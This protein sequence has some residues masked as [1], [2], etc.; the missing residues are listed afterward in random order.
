MSITASKLVGERITLD[1]WYTDEM[2]PGEQITS[3]EIQVQV[4]YGLDPDPLHIVYGA[5]EFEEEDYQKVTHQFH[6]GIPGCIYQ[7]ASVADTSAGRRLSRQR[8]LAILPSPSLVPPFTGTLY[9]THLYPLETREDLEHFVELTGRL[10][11]MP[12][13]EDGISHWLVQLSGVLRA[14]LISHSLPEEAIEHEILQLT[15]TLRV[16]LL[17]HQLPEEAI[18][19][20][21]LN[22]VGTLAVKLITHIQPEEAIEHSIIQITGTLT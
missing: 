8:K 5:G 22:I 12:F 21:I 2:F 13:L 10:R 19:H 18:E 14:L 11:E 17:T 20:T 6:L 16:L 15:G 3:V 7:I 9:T 1:F 4:Y